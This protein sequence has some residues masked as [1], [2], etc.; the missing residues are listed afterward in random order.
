MQSTLGS[1]TTRPVGPSNIPEINGTLKIDTSVH[2]LKNS[3]PSYNFTKEDALWLA[4][5]IEGEAGH[6]NDKN[7]HAV[8]WAMFNRFGILRHRVSAWSTFQNFLRL[9]S[10]TLQPMLRSR[11]AA[12][13]VWKKHKRNPSG[14]PVV[15]GQGTY[16]NSTVKKVQL[17]K[18]ID[19]QKK[20]WSRIGSDV[21]DLVVNILNGRIGNPGIGIATEF[22]S[23]RV[24]Y[25]NKYDRSP[26]RQEWKEYTINYAKNRCKRD[27]KGC[28]WVGEVSGI[29][30]MKNA[31]FIDNRF[32]NV[33][34]SAVTIR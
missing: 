6:R 17:K 20:P 27:I 22:V 26:T 14:H 15:V 32:R 25:I 29:D 11:G 30:Q 28:T 9:Y 8:V 33:P 5:F 7:G 1:G 16:K 13:R 4:R 3:Y 2:A 31:F 19:L 12:Q 10:T 24:F 34:A 18:H 21:R 23:T